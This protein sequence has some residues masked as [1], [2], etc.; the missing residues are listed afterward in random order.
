MLYLIIFKFITSTKAKS[1]VSFS[2]TVKSF[3]VSKAGANFKLILLST[4]ASFQYL[5]NK[6]KMILKYHYTNNF[7]KIF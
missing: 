4:P 7:E 3:I 6:I 2:F 1:N 5:K